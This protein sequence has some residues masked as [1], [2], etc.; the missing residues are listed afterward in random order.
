MKKLIEQLKGMTFREALDHLWTYYK[1]P[2]VIVIFSVI[3]V[4]SITTTVIENKRMHPV[5]NVGI[6]ADINLMYGQEVSGLLAEAF[7]DT[8]RYTAPVISEV[9]SP[10]N[11]E[12]V[13]AAL[14]LAARIT[15]GDIEALIGDTACIEYISRTGEGLTTVNI[16]DTTLGKNAEAL[17][18]SPL[19]Y[20]YF[21]NA[22]HTEEAVR[23]LEVI[24]EEP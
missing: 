11:E 21:N 6:L 19:L 1:W 7:P 3:M 2:A 10:A 15:S 12:D 17:G 14:Q 18:I 9:S 16:S 20:M 22:A 4:V 8:T 5:L 13:Y 24:R 23:L